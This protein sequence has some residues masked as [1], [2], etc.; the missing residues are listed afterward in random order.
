VAYENLF[1]INKPKRQTLIKVIFSK[2]LE[3]NIYCVLKCN[4]QIVIVVNYTY[5]NS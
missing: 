5:N 1:Y 3:L 4:L 2:L